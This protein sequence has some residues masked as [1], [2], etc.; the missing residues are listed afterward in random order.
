MK[1]KKKGISA[2]N[3]SRLCSANFPATH[4]AA[5]CMHILDRGCSYCTPLHL[6]RDWAQRSRSPPAQFFGH[7][8]SPDVDI[9]LHPEP[10]SAGPPQCIPSTGNLSAWLHH[11]L[12]QWRYVIWPSNRPKF[13]PVAPSSSDVLLK[14]PAQMAA[15]SDRGK[16][17]SNTAKEPSAVNRTA[18]FRGKNVLNAF[19]WRKK[20]GVWNTF[21]SFN[22]KYGQI[23]VP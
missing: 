22:G 19:G 9:A 23:H 17:A 4:G 13:Q 11:R 14:L 8:A 16:N 10:A 3:E 15:G 7:R 18:V 2:C 12:R 5:D 6:Q 1:K 20:H 21:A